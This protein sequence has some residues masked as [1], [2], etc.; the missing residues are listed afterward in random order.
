MSSTRVLGDTIDELPQRI[1]A[2]APTPVAHS[3]VGA[4]SAGPRRQNEDA[5]SGGAGVWAVADGMGGMTDGGIAARFVAQR[6]VALAPLDQSSDS[7]QF[8]RS[9]SADLVERV[10]VGTG[11]TLVGGV[12]RGSALKISSSGD[13]RVYL[14]RDGELSLVTR[15]HSVRELALDA[16]VDPS[17]LRHRQAN[18]LTSFLGQQPSEM[19]IGVRSVHVKPQDRVAFLSDGIH[20]FVEFYELRHLVTQVSLEQLPS[21]L[22]T[23]ARSL[24]S[25][26]DATAII[27][28]VA[29]T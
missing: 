19:T 13:S 3:W 12:L 5:F 9:L 23:K 15:D 2:G 7:R 10:G 14:S 20:R 28:E 17:S 21:T 18:A 16:G 25:L 22:I 26:D 29:A 1:D 8:V 27:V 11:S 6:F 24:G 4:S